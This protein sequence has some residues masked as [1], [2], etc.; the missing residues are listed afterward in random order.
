M[1][2]SYPH[3]A[4]ALALTVFAGALSAQTSAPRP[5][6]QSV[7]AKADGA[8]TAAAAAQAAA[9]AAAAA[10][11]T[12]QGTANAARTTADNAAAAANGIAIGTTLINPTIGDSTSACTSR[13]IGDTGNRGQT[14]VFGLRE[15]GDRPRFSV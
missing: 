15:I 2:H 10:A 3:T 4:L 6:L 5:T 9:N 13:E 7:D 14:T 8:A 1:S 11:S 12:A